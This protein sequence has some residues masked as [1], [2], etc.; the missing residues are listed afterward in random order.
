ML[1]KQDFKTVLKI[2][3]LIIILIKR[4]NPFLSHDKNI[5]ITHQNFSSAMLYSEDYN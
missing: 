5:N 4:K 3:F 1:L 2:I